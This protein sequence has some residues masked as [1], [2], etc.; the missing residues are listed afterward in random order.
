MYKSYVV[1]SEGWNSGKMQDRS[2]NDSRDGEHMFAVLDGHGHRPGT[3]EKTTDVVDF[4]KTNLAKVLW[5]E[6]EQWNNIKDSFVWCF[7]KLQASISAIGFLDGTTATVL[8]IDSDDNHH[9]AYVWDS[10]IYGVQGLKVEDI[11]WKDN[12]HKVKNIYKNEEYVRIEELY[13]ARL[14]RNM[15]YTG[16]IANLNIT[17]Y[18]GDR[19]TMWENYI[20]EVVS[21]K[22]KYDRYLL[23]S[24]GM[25][26]FSVDWI[27]DMIWWLDLESGL[28]AVLSG[29]K[30]KIKIALDF[31]EGREDCFSSQYTHLDHATML[32]VEKNG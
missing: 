18:L 7:D 23:T 28:D 10:P 4:V 20:P 5:Q 26:V 2:L 32:G 19:R 29:Y 11:V 31:L 14:M 6:R 8:Y 12:Y 24:D 21:L 22:K 25:D 27:S 17:R 15:Y 3:G 9:V 16:Y 1:Q 30:E 13:D